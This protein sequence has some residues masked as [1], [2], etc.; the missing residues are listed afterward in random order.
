MSRITKRGGLK[1]AGAPRRSRKNLAVAKR[2]GAPGGTPAHV[3][4]DE[5]DAIISLRRLRT[6]KAIPLE[7]V[8]KRYGYRVEG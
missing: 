2:K 7:K 6:E 5:A 1:E 4:E 8:L 3:T